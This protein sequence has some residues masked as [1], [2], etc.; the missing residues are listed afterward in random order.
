MNSVGTSIFILFMLLGNVSRIIIIPQLGHVNFSEA[1]LFG[2]ALI[3]GLIYLDVLVKKYAACVL[4]ILGFLAWNCTVGTIYHGLIASGFL[5]AIR[6][7]MLVIS[8]IIFGIVLHR[9]YA[10]NP[11]CLENTLLLIFVLSLIPAYAFLLFIA[12]SRE[13]WQLLSN[14]SIEFSGDPHQGR[15][16]GLYFDPNYY[17]ALLVFPLLI[18][19]I[20]YLRVGGYCNIF[21]FCIFFAS[22]FFTGSRS[23]IAIFV[24]S[25]LMLL[26]A[27]LVNK[28]VWRNYSVGNVGGRV[29]L[30]IFAGILS[31]W[32]IILISPDMLSDTYS[33]LIGE[34]DIRSTENRINSFI[35]G[36]EK[37]S[38]SF[39]LGHGYNFVVSDLQKI[40]GNSAVDSSIQMAII[41]WGYP[42]VTLGLCYFLVKFLNILLSTKGRPILEYITW[43]YMLVIIFFG[44]LFNNILFYPFWLF[45]VVS[46]LSYFCLDRNKRRSKKKNLTA[47]INTT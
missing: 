8:G 2:S 40:K 19:L 45:L 35:V 32:A 9:R 23:G 4:L 34:S 3:Y 6:L 11:T 31:I 20:R 42:I 46:I 7:A 41:A 13:L 33:R 26:S 30:I 16:F 18:A 24:I 22:I 12:D 14:H 1:L 15:L 38:E 25:F 17:A 44:S 5:Y 37:A 43:I 29:S 27:L 39:L 21:L 10:G 28:G 36:Y 47:F